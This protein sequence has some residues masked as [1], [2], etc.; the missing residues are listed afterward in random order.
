[1]KD[2]KY[3]FFRDQCKFDIA[4]HVSIFSLSGTTTPPR[5]H[6]D[7]RPRRS[8]TQPARSLR[9]Q[10]RHWPG[11]LGTALPGGARRRHHGAADGPPGGS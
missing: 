9:R 8:P 7:R 1:M 2:P 5:P 6:R 11:P 10:P 3:I 4:S